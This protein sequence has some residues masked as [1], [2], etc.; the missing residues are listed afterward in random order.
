MGF[1]T[2]QNEG[3][4]LAGALNGGSG[5][6]GS[7]PEGSQVELTALRTAALLDLSSFEAARISLSSGC[8]A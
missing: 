2:Q 3:R 5:K 1:I 7:V 4:A 8:R 6:G